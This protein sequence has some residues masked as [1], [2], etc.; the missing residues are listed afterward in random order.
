M[1]RTRGGI[2]GS[3]YVMA[4]VATNFSAML[5]GDLAWGTVYCR[6]VELE[7]ESTMSPKTPVGT[8]QIKITLKG[9]K[10]SI[11][12][13]VSAPCDIT[14]SRLHDVIQFAMGWRDCHLHEFVISDKRYG[15]ASPEASDFDDG[16]LDEE[17]ARLNKVVRPDQK[18][19][20]CY[21]FGDDWIH[22]IQIEREIVS[23]GERAVHCLTGKNACPPEDCGGPH[24]YARL[25]AI[26]SDPDHEEHEQML[27]WAGTDVDPHAF[28]AKQTDRLLSLVKV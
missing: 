7:S 10:P 28:D 14:L 22:E 24:G 18:F 4:I 15:R 19:L 13:R 1:H 8:Y 27:D 25:L 3:R 16:L 17:R 20:Y 26:L 21:D 23:D 9:V 11:W 2:K 5:A 6:L 12:R